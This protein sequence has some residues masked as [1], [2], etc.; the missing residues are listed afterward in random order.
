MSIEIRPFQPGDENGICTAHT[1]A[2]REICR[3]HYTS[4]QID[5]WTARI[6]PAMYLNSIAT[7]GE[8]FW[9]ID[10]A[11]Q[12]GGFAGWYGANIQGFYLHPDYTG[13]GLASRLFQAVENEFWTKSGHD[14]C[15]IES[16][17]TAKPFYEKMGFTPRSAAVHHLRDGTALD[18]WLMDKARP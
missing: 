6:S 1:C 12:I 7:N 11:G 9:V 15:A 5:S 16:T 17:L 14:T 13:Q 3:K 8:R 10:D 4:A 18:I 2:I